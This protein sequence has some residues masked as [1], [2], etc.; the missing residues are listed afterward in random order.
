MVFVVCLYLF[1]TYYCYC[2]V[3]IIKIKKEKMDDYEDYFVEG[4]F[5]LTKELL[6]RV[7]VLSTFSNESF[8]INKEGNI[9]FLNSDS[10]QTIKKFSSNLVNI[11]K[12]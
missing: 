9:F 3:Y 11:T 12:C 10:I 2:F 7:P 1:F 5:K 6:E 8:A 4:K